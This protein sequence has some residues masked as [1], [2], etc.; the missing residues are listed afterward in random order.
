MFFSDQGMMS[1]GFRAIISELQS[2]MHE[3]KQTDSP[4]QEG[5]PDRKT[6]LNFMSQAAE[7]VLIPNYSEIRQI[8]G[9]V[10]ED[11]TEKEPPD[12]LEPKP[13]EANPGHFFEIPTKADILHSAESPEIEPMSLEHPEKPKHEYEKSFMEPFSSQVS[14][15]ELMSLEH[16]E[17]PNHEYEQSVLEPFSSQVS[18]KELM[19]L[20]HPEK[21]NHEYEQSVLEP[22]LS[23]VSDKE[24]MSL[25]HPEKPKHEYEKS[26]LEL[27]LSQVSDKEPMSLEH[28]ERPNHE[29]EQSIM[30]PFA[31]KGL[32]LETENPVLDHLKVAPKGGFI[33]SAPEN[34]IQDKCDTGKDNS[35]ELHI[36]LKQV[37]SKSNNNNKLIHPEL[38]SGESSVAKIFEAQAEVIHRHIS[39]TLDATGVANNLNPQLKQVAMPLDQDAYRTEHKVMGQVVARLFTGV[40]QGSQNMTIHLYPPELGKVKVRIISNKG[41]ISVRL[42]SMNQ[43]VGGILEK[44]L[45]LLQQSLEDQ[46]IVLSDLRVTVESGNE[47]KSRSD[48]QEFLWKNREFSTSEISKE[49]DETVI[50]GESLTWSAP[51][52]G[53]SLRV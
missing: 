13:K 47:E 26:V 16:P 37:L 44:Y 5:I 29:Y 46:G 36:F 53:L 2:K 22:F 27:F 40:R 1:F 48:D 17:K 9:L 3:E 50:L 10:H 4:F 39:P 18:D 34:Q 31:S 14:D 41:D 24:L 11:P 20:E 23:Q 43:Q 25:E 35:R 42:H 51:S 38:N 6:F 49:N 8:E 45:P 30:E 7:Q 28:P 52:Q 32:N 33:F 19:S 12:I 15:K 21:P